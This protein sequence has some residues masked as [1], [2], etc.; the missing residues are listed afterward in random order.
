M[1]KKSHLTDAGAFLLAWLYCLLDHL[2]DAGM[3]SL[4]G[5]GCEQFE[6]ENFFT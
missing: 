4:E 1:I 2:K 6:R 5:N 3:L